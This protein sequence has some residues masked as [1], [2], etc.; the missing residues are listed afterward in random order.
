MNGTVKCLQQA[1][2]GRW[3]VMPP[4][5][6]HTAGSMRSSSRPPARPACLA[7]PSAAQVSPRRAGEV[8]DRGHLASVFSKTSIPPSTGRAQVPLKR[9]LCSHTCLHPTLNSVL[10]AFAVCHKWCGRCGD[11][12][13][14]VEDKRQG[15]P[16]CRVHVLVGK[17]ILKVN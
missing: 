14:L 9:C 2:S 8:E 12:G 5:V 16:A 17:Q 15:V 6:S 4:R 11:V 3:G 1:K 10:W 13:A 7:T